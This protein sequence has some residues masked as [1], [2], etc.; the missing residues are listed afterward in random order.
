MKRFVTILLIFA[1]S[2]NILAG[3][4]LP[5]ETNA[6]QTPFSISTVNPPTFN[7]PTVEHTAVPSLPIPPS[8][9]T[10]MYAEYYDILSK[11]VS[12]NGFEGDFF[13]Y[14][15]LTY[16]ELI[17]FDRDGID[18]LVCI[19]RDGEYVPKLQVYQYLNGHVVKIIDQ[20]SGLASDNIPLIQFIRKG[21]QRFV[22]IGEDNLYVSYQNLQVYGI[23][24]HQLVETQFYCDYDV[25]RGILEGDVDNNGE[26]AIKLINCTIDGQPVMRAEY[27]MQLAE[28]GLPA[29]GFYWQKYDDV[30]GEY[31]GE[32]GFEE[33]MKNIM[34][35]Y[36]KANPNQSAATMQTVYLDLTYIDEDTVIQDVLAHYPKGLEEILVSY[37]TSETLFSAFPR[38]QHIG[39]EYYIL[40]RSYPEFLGLPT[41]EVFFCIEDPQ[42]NP[43][44][45]ASSPFWQIR[46]P[47][48]VIPK[49]IAVLEQSENGN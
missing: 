32:Y 48:H 41:G 8:D 34:P 49:L 10:E 46:I 24:Q 20:Y 44:A 40:A 5:V 37:L 47:E 21:N 28:F 29:W 26:E 4:I 19:F 7:P 17:D 15:G 18:E 31:L 23:E 38:K 42:R 36:Q 27:E 3:C 1:F 35:I 45:F 6:F 14:S 22:C 16:V 39:T 11:I 12:Q 25:D 9:T 13:E 33:L 43:D 2:V 30:T